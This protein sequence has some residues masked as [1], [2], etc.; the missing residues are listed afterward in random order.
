MA[1]LNGFPLWSNGRVLFGLVSYNAPCVF[2]VLVR[3]GVPQDYIVQASVKTVNTG[4]VQGDFTTFY[5]GRSSL[6]AYVLLDLHPKN[7]KESRTYFLNL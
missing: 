4:L 2:C 6:R 1:I 7:S 3:K 5:H